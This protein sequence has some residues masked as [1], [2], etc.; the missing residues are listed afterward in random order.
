MNEDVEDIDV[1][2]GPGQEVD[3]DIEDVDNVPGQEVDEDI[4]DVDNV[5]GQEVDED[6]DD[7]DDVDDIILIRRW[8]KTPSSKSCKVRKQSPQDFVDQASGWPG[9]LSNYI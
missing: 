7:V 4:E 1:D 8:M 2:D 5:P 3:K 6:I 9:H